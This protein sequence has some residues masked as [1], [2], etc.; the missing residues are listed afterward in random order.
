MAAQ[1][2]NEHFAEDVVKF[3]EN[4]KKRPAGSLKM[5]QVASEQMSCVTS[6][7]GLK[8]LSRALL[9]GCEGALRGIVSDKSALGIVSPDF[10]NIASW[11]GA[12]LNRIVFADKA[13]PGTRRMLKH[14]T[15]VVLI[16]TVGLTWIGM[17]EAKKEMPG[18]E[19]REGFNLLEELLVGLAF[20]T[21]F[22][23]LIF[24][25]IG[26]SLTAS[27]EGSKLIAAIWE[28][29]ALGC[30]MI[31]YAKGNEPLEVSILELVL[32]KLQNNLME[33]DRSLGD[34]IER[35]E[36]D[37]GNVGEFRSFLRQ[38]ILSIENQDIDSFVDSC[39]MLLASNGIS[40]EH[41]KTDCE[42]IKQMFS[43]FSYAFEAGMTSKQTAINFV[44]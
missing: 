18:K 11:V 17:A 13:D 40:T 38:I 39:L 2:T 37:A 6:C 4:Q 22:P 23:K 14:V 30:L 9:I 10:D 15:E 26:D 35:G 25:E 5:L 41:L 42:M 28:S 43:T 34:K 44:G 3:E 1:N 16:A 20:T 33:I 21:D 27:K 31:A 7:L 24:R 12:A 29:A 8:S 19:D 32:G 36:L